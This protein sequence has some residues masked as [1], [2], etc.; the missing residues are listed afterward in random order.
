MPEKLELKDFVGQQITLHVCVPAG[1][2]SVIVTGLVR[3][4]DH[5]TPFIAVDSAHFRM[6]TTM[7]KC[8]T[9][10]EYRIEY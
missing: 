4:I 6:D 3:P 9:G 5:K 10:K 2:C 1:G 7:V 8:L